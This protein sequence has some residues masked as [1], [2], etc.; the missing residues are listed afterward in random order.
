MA[1]I[2]LLPAA[3]AL[4]LLL[5]GCGGGSS[6]TGPGG[7]PTPAPTPTPFALAG[8]YSGTYAGLEVG[9]WTGTIGNDRSMSITVN[10]SSVGTFTT[11]GTVETNGAI[12]FRVTA[13]GFVINWQGQFT[14]S[15]GGVTGN[16]TWSST[17]G[18]SGTWTGSRR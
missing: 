17:S 10:S 12:S 4:S 5:P 6:T 14:A 9:T 15:G 11:T 8:S 13:G 3:V 7:T 16:G 2:S 1:R 18:T